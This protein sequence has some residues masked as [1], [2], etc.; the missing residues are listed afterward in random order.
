MIG[1]RTSSDASRM[2]LRCR[3]RAAGGPMLTKATHDVFD[4]DD[5][6]VDHRARA[7]ITRPASTMVF[8]VAP[9]K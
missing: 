8:M 2:I 4:I 7:A 5:G 9:R 1:L 3:T 6:V